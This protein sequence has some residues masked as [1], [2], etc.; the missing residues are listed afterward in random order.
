MNS[1]SLTSSKE[2]PY[3]I[4]SVIISLFIYIIATV[5]LIGIAIA[6]A[7]FGFV[8]FSNA[9]MLGSIRGNGVR[10]NERQF[11]DIYERVVDLSQQMN[12]TRVP[13]VF[14]IHSEGA[15]NAFA[16]R[17]LGRNMVVIYSEVF[18]LARE[19]GAKELDF[20]IAHELAHIKRRH[21]WKSILVMPANFIPFLSQAYS[22]ACEYTCDRKAAYYIQD[23]AAAKRALTILSI[24][25]GLYTEVN[26]VAYLE[27]IHSESNVAVW[28]AE[29]LS[30]HPLLPKRIQAVGQ[31]MR[32]E[33]TPNFQTNTG[34]IALGATIS[35]AILV[36]SYIGAIVAL[37]FGIGLF[38]TIFPAADDE[39]IDFNA[40]PLMGATMDGDFAAVEK[41]INEGADIYAVD[42]E[43]TTALHYAVYFGDFDIVKLLLE[44]GA[45]P[46][47]IDDYSTAFTTALA[48]E[49]FDIAVLL[50]EFGA[51]PTLKNPEGESPLAYF[52]VTTLEE[53]E[54]VLYRLNS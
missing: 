26:D 14:V 3:F 33:G 51:D 24:G 29:I 10:V 32:V 18:E 27:Q 48:N 38:S 41:L 37:T 1:Q 4:F 35:G 9:I 40:T 44:S 36:V 49:F 53:F 7:L 11:P 8:L 16:T 21:V 13:D 42:D 15:F 46:N 34:K 12:L 23:G 31:F 5:S 43:S 54:D 39:F 28:F 6:L 20:I 45:N 25:K 17:F 19:R 30:T 50:Y 22:R 47:D 2:T 52:G